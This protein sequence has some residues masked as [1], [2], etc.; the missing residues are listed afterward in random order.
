VRD[1]T[2]EVV[3]QLRRD[4]EVDFAPQGEAV[5]GQRS[6]SPELRS[7]LRDPLGVAKVPSGAVQFNPDAS[8]RN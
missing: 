7:F 4:G 1:C 5:L 3:A 6:C 8:Y 2:R